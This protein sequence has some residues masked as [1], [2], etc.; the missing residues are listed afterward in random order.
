MTLQS[1]PS[2]TPVAWAGAQ[3][4]PQKP[5]LAR[6]VSVLTLQPVPLQ[7]AVP[8]G[9]GETSHCPMAH[10]QLPGVAKQSF[11]HEPH[12]RGSAAV[13][14]LQP[15][16]G[17]PSQFSNPRSQLSTSHAAFSHFA[18]AW[19]SEQ[20][21]S[22]VPQFEASLRRSISQPSSEDELQFPNPSSQDSTS[23]A[24]ETHVAVALGVV[25]GVQ[26]VSEHPYAG[27]AISTH[28]PSQSFFPSPH[29]PPAPAAP[30][31]PPVTAPALPPV[32]PPAPAT[33][34]PALPPEASRE[35][36]DLP[37]VPPEPGP[38]SPVSV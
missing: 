38:P 33:L 9:Q 10:S 15:V 19:G 3:V 17:S 37:P 30:P 25:H 31:A 32:A 27:S 4:L 23:H 5:Q 8:V 11:V 6:D 29:P 24:P 2:Q 26:L 22:Q 16:E 28:E 12:A 36:S 13:L 20:S 7:L 21:R 14:T 1:P 35:A 18:L 34:L